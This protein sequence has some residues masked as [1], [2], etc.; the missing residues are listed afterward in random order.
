MHQTLSARKREVL[1][2]VAETRME[3]FMAM[4]AAKGRVSRTW[5]RVKVP[6]R[7]ARIGL[8]IGGSALG[9]W[10]LRRLF[11]K[12]IVA[13]AVQT[14]F[15]AGGG[16]LSSLTYLLVQ[17]AALTLLP[18]LKTRAQG[19]EWGDFLKRLHPAHIFFRWIGLEK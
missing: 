10:A 6:S 4:D 3:V 19:A 16:A 5:D 8:A 14:T 11:H 1:I 7:V 18:W 17:V 15:P 13:P 9:M 12:K 2:Q